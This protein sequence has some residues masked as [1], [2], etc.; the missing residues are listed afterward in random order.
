M[1]LSGLSPTSSFTGYGPGELKTVIWLL[2]RHKVSVWTIIVV[3]IYKFWNWFSVFHRIYRAIFLV[4][5]FSPSCTFPVQSPCLDERN[6]IG[7]FI[8]HRVFRA[9]H[10]EKVHFKRRDKN[11]LHKEMTPSNFLVGGGAGRCNW[12]SNPLGPLSYRTSRKEGMG[13]WK[14]GKRGGNLHASIWIGS[15]TSLSEGGVHLTQLPSAG[16][17]ISICSTK[18]I[19]SHGL[20]RTGWTGLVWLPFKTSTRSTT[21][22][23]TFCISALASS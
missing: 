15:I 16:Y 22:D 5:M 9:F 6:W 19:H 14:C 2:W 17:D 12:Y 8:F 4:V 18:F 3:T 1:K 7:F 21:E 23:R 11:K 10:Y 20:T 13:E